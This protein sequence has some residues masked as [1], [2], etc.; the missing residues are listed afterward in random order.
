MRRVIFSLSAEDVVRKP[1]STFAPTCT[2]TNEAA[3]TSTGSISRAMGPKTRPSKSDEFSVI[4]S[5]SSMLCLAS[6]RM[7]SSFWAEVESRL[8]QWLRTTWVLRLA[9]SAAILHAARDVS[10]STRAVSFSVRAALSWRTLAAPASASGRAPTRA[11]ALS[12]STSSLRSSAA[13][14]ALSSRA[15]VTSSWALRISASR[16]ESTARWRATRRSSASLQAFSASVSAR[17]AAAWAASSALTGASAA[18]MARW[19]FLASSFTS[20]ALA[21]S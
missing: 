7:T 1:R 18:S 9:R 4:Q 15:A 12:T 8:L 11:L 14:L 2:S 17:L 3:C 5:L 13:R 21:L 10:A 19:A 6:R 16:S 20:L